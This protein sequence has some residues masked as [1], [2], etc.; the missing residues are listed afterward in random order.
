MNKFI[1]KIQRFLNGRYG[2]DELYKFML[3][4]CLIIIIVNMFVNSV[5]LRV[6]ELIVFGVS[7][8][9]FLSKKKSKR[10]KENKKYLEI[11]GK[12]RGYFDYQ[13]KKYKDRNTHMYKKCPKCRQKLRLPLKKGIHTVKCPSCKEKFEVKC[14]RNEKIEVEIVK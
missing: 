14:R 4:I 1:N 10:S 7:L 6:L 8:Y 13:K 11:V 9:R 3:I 2:P 12:I 5:I